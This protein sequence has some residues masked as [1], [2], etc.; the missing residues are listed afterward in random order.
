MLP[1]LFDEHVDPWLGR[2]DL[3]SHSLDLGDQRKIGVMGA[4]GRVRP[5][6]A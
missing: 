5:D 2:R 6:L 1:A 4:M 3:R